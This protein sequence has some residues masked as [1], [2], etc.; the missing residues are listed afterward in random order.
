M[1]Q[2]YVHVREHVRTCYAL[3]VNLYNTVITCITVLHRCEIK[4][5][6]VTTMDQC[7]FECYQMLYIFVTIREHHVHVLQH[8]IMSCTTT[9]LQY[10]MSGNVTTCNT[11]L[12]R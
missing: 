11:M 4:M 1:L 12:V 8:Y 7:E 10:Y 2:C 6:D 5:S 9:L 3:N